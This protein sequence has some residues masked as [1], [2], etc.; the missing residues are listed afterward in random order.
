MKNIQVYATPT[1]DYLVFCLG[2]FTLDEI[3]LMRNAVNYY[4][5]YLKKL[6]KSKMERI[7]CGIDLATVKESLEDCKKLN[8]MFDKFLDKG[9][10]DSLAIE[11]VVVLNYGALNVLGKYFNDCLQDIADDPSD[12]EYKKLEP[13]ILEA[14][15]FIDI[16]QKKLLKMENIILEF[17]K[18]NGIKN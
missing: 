4:T 12:L 5:D 9:I 17:E 7:F 1:K 8:K 6:S 13:K 3:G 16:I 14:L 18:K 11:D 10:G 15:D 2:N